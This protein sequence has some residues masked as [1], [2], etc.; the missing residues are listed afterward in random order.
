[1]RVRL[2]ALSLCLTLG[3]CATDRDPLAVYRIDPAAFGI[4][5][6]TLYSMGI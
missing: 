2:L 5:L 4:P 1:M 3:F 6:V